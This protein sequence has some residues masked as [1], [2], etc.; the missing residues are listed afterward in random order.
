MMSNLYFQL[1]FDA[2]KTSVPGIRR[3][4]PR[5]TCMLKVR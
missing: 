4:S 5:G 3:F 2:Q 1:D